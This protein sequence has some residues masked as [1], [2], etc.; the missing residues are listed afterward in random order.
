MPQVHKTTFIS[1]LLMVC[2]WTLPLQILSKYITFMSRYI[3][4]GPKYLSGA[5][6]FLQNIYPDFDIDRS[7]SLIKAAITGSKKIQ[8]DPVYQKLLLCLHHLLHFVTHARKNNCFDELLFTTILL[9]AF[10]TCL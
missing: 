4:S 3:A 8:A 6:Y 7:H 1:A 10:Y 5:G 9:C 2:H